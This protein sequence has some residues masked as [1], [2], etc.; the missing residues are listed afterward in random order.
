[1]RADFVLLGTRDC[2]HVTGDPSFKPRHGHLRDGSQTDLALNL[3]DT[4]VRWYGKPVLLTTRV[5]ESQSLKPAGDVAID[6]T[7]SGSLHAGG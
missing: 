6:P 1:M 2:F 3:Q 7:S 4:N 5:L